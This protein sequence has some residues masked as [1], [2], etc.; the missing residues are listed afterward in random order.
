MIGNQLNAHSEPEKRS[1]RVMG[2][3]QENFEFT[4]IQKPFKDLN[5]IQNSTSRSSKIT[6]KQHMSFR[7]NSS[8]ELKVSSAHGGILA[9]F[10][11]SCLDAR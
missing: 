5:E 1:T 9:L 4:N 6:N 11:R 10:L 8:S 3:G 7:E 2:L